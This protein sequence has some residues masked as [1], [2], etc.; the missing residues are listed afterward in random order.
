MNSN[1]PGKNG[2]LV[3]WGT[4]DLGKPRVR[5]LIKAPETTFPAS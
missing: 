2:P 4:Y 5:L 3:F 1:Q